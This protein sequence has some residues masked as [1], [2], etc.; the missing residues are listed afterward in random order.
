M[1]Q[2]TTKFIVWEKYIP[3]FS[4]KNDV[5][6]PGHN[7]FKPKEEDEPYYE[8]GDVRIID[9][10]N[11]MEDALEHRQPKRTLY[12]PFGILPLTDYNDLSKVFNFWVG[13][14]NFYLSKKVITLLAR[15]PGV[16][17]LDPMTPYRFR[18]SIGKAFVS[19]EVKIAIQN[20]LDC[21]VKPD[22]QENIPHP[23]Y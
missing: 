22:V 4:S 12:T 11:I 16:E 3:A 18:I 10:E 13:H 2:K 17:T 23:K 9:V 5:E 14:T 20:R 1:E 19:S 21:S 6:F 15:T 8:D 7:G